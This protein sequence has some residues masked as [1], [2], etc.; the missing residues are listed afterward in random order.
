MVGP[1]SPAPS[2]LLPLSDSSRAPPSWY[3]SIHT[4]IHAGYI[5]VYVASFIL[6]TNMKRSRPRRPSHP[7][8]FLLSHVIQCPLRPPPPLGLDG[9]SGPVSPARSDGS[10][11]S[12]HLNTS[13]RSNGEEGHRD[14]E[15]AEAE[16]YALPQP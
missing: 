8:P 3:D 12:N 15:D 14:D 6:N 11:F 1:S 10:C 13:F 7:S 4:Y 2:P 9:V 5:S 16:G